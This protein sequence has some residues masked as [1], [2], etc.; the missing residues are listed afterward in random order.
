MGCDLF[1]EISVREEVEVAKRIIDNLYIRWRYNQS[2]QSNY[3]H[4]QQQQ[5]LLQPQQSLAAMATSSHH[6]GRRCL[7][8]FAGRCSAN[9]SNSMDVISEREDAVLPISLSLGTTSATSQVRLTIHSNNS[10]RLLF[11]FNRVTFT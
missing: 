7:E 2:H 10:S 8:T 3:Q 9:K 1:F 6:F 5:H 4:V 11:L